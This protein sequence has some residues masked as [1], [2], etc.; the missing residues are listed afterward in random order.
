MAMSKKSDVAQDK[1]MIKKAITQH[2]QHM[3]GGKKEEIK[4]RKGGKMKG[5][6]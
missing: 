2:D 3:H 1:K 4:L 6:K 5:K